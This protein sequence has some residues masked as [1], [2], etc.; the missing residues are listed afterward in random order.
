VNRRILRVGADND[1]VVQLQQSPGVIGSTG[2]PPVGP[3]RLPEPLRRFLDNRLRAGAI[4]G[5]VGLVLIL[6]AIVAKLGWTVFLP[7]LCVLAVGAWFMSRGHDSSGTRTMFAYCVALAVL[8]V[9]MGWIHPQRWAQPG[10]KLTSAGPVLLGRHGGEVFFFDDGLF[11][12]RNIATGMLTWQ[13]RGGSTS[14][15]L[16]TSTGI[17]LQDPNDPASAQK[18]SLSTGR[19]Y[20]T[21]H[22]PKSPAHVL[23][24]SADG[25]LT[26]APTEK[27]KRKILARM[28]GVSDHERVLT[29]VRWG[30]VAARLVDASDATGHRYTRLDIVD[31][32]TTET[33]RVSR[34]TGL[35]LIDGVLVVDS[36]QP[37][38]IA[39]LRHAPAKAL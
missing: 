14:H 21:V 12:A 23:T 2:K 26:G 29:T 27:L 16:V 15:A 28:P 6:L 10:W 19:P 7:A 3:R 5:G 1:A 20:A 33:Y 9:G 11:S 39:L 13:F 4:I 24:I 38:V 8:F 36:P 30:D 31:G 34:A 17:L 35:Q 22:W 25:H 18:Y 32:P 37:H